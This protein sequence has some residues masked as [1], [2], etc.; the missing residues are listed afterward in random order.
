MGVLGTVV[1][2]IVRAAGAVARAI[3]SKRRTSTRDSKEGTP[4]PAQR[5]GPRAPAIVITRGQRKK[6]IQDAKRRG[7]PYERVMRAQIILVLAADPCVTAASAALGVDRKTVRLWRDRFLAGGRKGLDTRKRPGRPVLI[8]PVSRTQLVGMACGQPADFG[9][10]FRETWTI[11][12]LLEAYRER[13]PDLAPLSHGTVVRILNGADIRPHRM[14]V[15]LH[16]PD[17]KFRE[18]ATAICRLYRRPPPG[19]VVL[20]IDEKTGMQAKSRKFATKPAA[21]G[22]AGRLEFEYKRHGTL[23]LIAA[24][25]PHTGEVFGEV[26][27]DRKLAT[28]M[29]FM[30]AVAEHF[31][32]ADIHV[33]WDNL[34]THLD[35]RDRRWS[36]FSARHGGRFHFH[37]TPIHGS[38]VNQVE[39]FFSI[40]ARRVL[41][42]ASHPG[43][44]A[45]SSAVLGFIDH[46]NKHEA[47]PFRWTFKGYPL[48][49]GKKAA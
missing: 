5:R 26:Y 6:L 36:E 7:S 45:L 34:N 41:R 20:C 17:P 3:A 49:M 22:K 37:L 30:E 16:S 40:L 24:L 31:S 2:G 12:S 14:R 23:T 46:W 1:A 13:N 21:P 33:V 4:E 38:W 35:G 27:P 32:G 43:K 11:G 9:V 28:L 10:P 19:S 47:H 8:D 44:K 25:N 39:C 42:H 29:R 18:K 15:W 48:Q